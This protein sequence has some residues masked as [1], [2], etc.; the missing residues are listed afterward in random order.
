MIHSLREFFLVSWK[1][2]ILAK[3]YFGEWQAKP[4]L[5]CPNLRN[6]SVRGYFGKTHFG[7]W[8]KYLILARTI[9]RFLSEFANFVKISS[10]NGGLRVLFVEILAF[11]GIK[12]YFWKVQNNILDMTLITF[13]HNFFNGGFSTSTFDIDCSVLEYTFFL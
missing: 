11:F 13:N 12:A 10:L 4:V 8:A 3:P 1:F 5:F 9:W 2:S 6:F 7:D